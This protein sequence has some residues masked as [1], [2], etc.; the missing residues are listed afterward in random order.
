MGASFKMF[1]KLYIKYLIQ[2]LLVLK[3]C[4][5]FTK[6]DVLQKCSAGRH[7]LTQYLTEHINLHDLFKQIYLRKHVL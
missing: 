7:T 1:L 5:I 4:Y 6:L 2:S 3:N